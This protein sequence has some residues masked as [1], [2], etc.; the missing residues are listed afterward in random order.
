[1]VKPISYPITERTYFTTSSEAVTFAKM[2]E[3]L[4]HHIVSNYGYVAGEKEPY[5]VETM[6][7]P[8]RSKDELL[9]LAGI[10]A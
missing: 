8:F 7:D 10:I 5:Y 1:M 9:K 3:K 4:K 2:I 6:N